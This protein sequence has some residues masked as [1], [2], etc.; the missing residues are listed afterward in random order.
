MSEKEKTKEKKENERSIQKKLNVL[1]KIMPEK[2]KKNFL[3]LHEITKLIEDSQLGNKDAEISIELVMTKDKKSFNIQTLNKFDEI[4]FETF[5]IC[6]KIF[7]NSGEITLYPYHKGL[8]EN[9][10]CM[11]ITFKAKQ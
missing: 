6:Q 11:K 3:V 1:R 4:Q 10:Y 2:D 7:K 5:K 9:R 8:P